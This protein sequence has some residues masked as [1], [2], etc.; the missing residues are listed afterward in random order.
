MGEKREFKGIWIPAEIWLCR[1][2]SITEKCLLAEIDS[3]SGTSI[4]CIASNKYLADFL[5]IKEDMIRRYISNLKKLGLVV[6]IGFDGRTREL[7]TTLSDLEKILDQEEIPGLTRKKLSSRPGISRN[8][9][10]IEYNINNNIEKNIEFLGDSNESLKTKEAKASL[11]SNSFKKDNTPKEKEFNTTPIENNKDF[12]FLLKEWNSIP[13]ATK[14]N[15]IDTKTVADAFAWYNRLL[16]GSFSRHATNVTADWLKNIDAP[17]KW[18]SKK[19]TIEEIKEGIRRIGLQWQNGYWPF[20]IEEKKKIL[21][22][23]LPASFYSPYN[24][25]C[26]SVFIKVMAKEPIQNGQLTETEETEYKKYLDMYEIVLTIN[27]RDKPKI[28][29]Y[30]KSILNIHKTVCNSLIKVNDEKI[31]RHHIEEELGSNF[32]AAIGFIN[33]PEILIKN[34]AD[35]IYECKMSWKDFKLNAISF[36]PHGGLWDKFIEWL[37]HKYNVKLWLEDDEA[38]YLAMRYSNYKKESNNKPKKEKN[39]KKRIKELE[40][41]IKRKEQPED[42]LMLFEEELKKLKFESERKAM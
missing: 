5:G 2:L 26:P 7:K 6:Q 13:N 18:L 9:I 39:I 28:V 4:G 40:E 38:E 31:E 19:W 17:L 12:I 34:H 30:I 33:V 21:P 29:K 27:D 23:S 14:H 41:I 37:E 15:K 35:F 24:K 25:N 16:D 22:K 42:V 3:F 20:T 10:N 36:S 8:P 1:V 32:N 11:K